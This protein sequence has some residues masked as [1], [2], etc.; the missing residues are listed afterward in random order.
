MAAVVFGKARNGYIKKKSF[1]NEKYETKR[2]ALSCFEY[3]SQIMRY[4]RYVS[5]LRLQYF[6]STF[7]LRE[8]SSVKIIS[9]RMA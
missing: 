4:K 8:A 2:T 3:L 7:S 9:T 6:L 1:S 5:V